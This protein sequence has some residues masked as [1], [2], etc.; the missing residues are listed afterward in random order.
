MNVKVWTKPICSIYILEVAMKTIKMATSDENL[1][2]KAIK[3]VLQ[4]LSEKFSENA[5]PVWI[6]NEIFQEISKITRNP[7][8]FEK[9][10][11]E[12]NIIALKVS[13]KIRKHIYEG[14]TFNERLKRALAAAVTGNVIDFGT[15]KHEFDLNR[16]KDMYF[17]A[18]E[19]GFSIDDSKHLLK[20]LKAKNPKIL[21]IGDNAGEIAFDK[22]LIELFLEKGVDVTFV[23]KDKPISNDATLNDA[24]QV[25]LT[26]LVKVI[27]TGS[28]NLGVNFNKVSKEFLE[29]FNKSTFIIAKGQSNYECFTWFKNH[30]NKPIFLLLRTKCEPIAKNLKTT[31][32]KNILKLYV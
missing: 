11:K 24:K 19:Q 12:S 2:F 30:I 29:E 3:K 13:E 14:E 22:L 31:V 17:E 7:D 27:T 10:K 21:Y 4:I 6:S 9:I 8:P 1:Q 18:L 26:K 16:L 32:G 23:V 15:A 5:M 20:M 28:N 25:K